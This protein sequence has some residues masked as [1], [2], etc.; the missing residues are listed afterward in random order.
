VVHVRFLLGGAV[1]LFSIAT[2]LALA[3]LVGV[4]TS[5]TAV[6]IMAT[7][8]TFFA[9][10]FLAGHDRLEAAVTSVWSARAIHGA[11]IFLPKFL[12]MSKAVVMIV[13]G[14]EFSRIDVPI[15]PMAFV[16]TG[17]FAIGC[18]ALASFL[19]QRKEF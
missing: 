12:E 19:F 11:Y 8:A 16:T 2:L 17:I 6:S 7:F 3:F 5:S 9:A 4:V 18:L 15:D 1:I 10:L 13:S 14:G